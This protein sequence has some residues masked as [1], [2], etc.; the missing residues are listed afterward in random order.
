M[1]RRHPYPARGELEILL[2]GPRTKACGIDWWIN[3]RGNLGF[4]SISNF[5]TRLCDWKGRFSIKF[6]RI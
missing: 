5:K 2:A 4:S 1:A 3:K 6:P